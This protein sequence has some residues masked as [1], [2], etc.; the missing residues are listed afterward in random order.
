MRSRVPFHDYGIIPHAMRLYS[1]AY[2]L[3]S[4]AQ[5]CSGEEIVA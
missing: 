1:Q 2:I 3:P 5:I 4:G